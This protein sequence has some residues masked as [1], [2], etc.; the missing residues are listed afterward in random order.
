[1]P[2]WQFWR[3]PCCCSP[4]RAYLLFV[5]VPL[6]SDVANPYFEYA[7]ETVDFHKTPYLDFL[8]EYPPL[9]CWAISAPRLFNAT[10]L[11]PGFAPEAG[12]AAFGDY[13]AAFRW[14][15]FLCDVVT[16]AALTT[17]AWLRRPKMVGWMAVLYVVTSTVFGHLL[18]DRLDVALLMFVSLWGLAWVVSLDDI[19]H[20]V[21]WSAAAYAFLGLG[22]SL[23]LIPIVAVPFV[24]LADWCRSTAGALDDW[25]RALA[26]AIAAPFA[27]QYAI[28]GPDVFALFQHHAEHDIQ[29]ESFYSTLLMMLRPV[30]DISIHWEHSHGGFNLA[31]DLTAS[32]RTVSRVLLIAFFLTMGIWTLAR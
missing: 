9:A 6:V 12:D 28:S 23:K 1:M 32:M 4:S 11:E 18:Y 15:M 25:N 5:L 31:G 27:I 8:V 24:V 10:R 7:V 17:I 13:H 22:I 29:L 19:R 14:Q 26:L 30:S 3:S 20:S 2:R 21:A 16:F